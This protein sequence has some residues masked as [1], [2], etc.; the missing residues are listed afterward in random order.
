MPQPAIQHSSI[1]TPERPWHARPGRRAR[2]RP[3]IRTP[4]APAA[5]RSPYTEERQQPRESRLAGCTPDD[6]PP[7]RARPGERTP[8]RQED[9]APRRSPPHP[10]ADRAPGGYSEEYATAG[11]RN[12]A[13]T[14]TIRAQGY[15]G[16]TIDLALK[17]NGGLCCIQAV[18]PASTAAA[19]G[20]ARLSCRSG[21]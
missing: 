15:Y 1:C 10:A 19:F 9:H 14:S 6:P 20:S 21:R 13:M 17:C 16:P 18:E 11:M 12:A 2:H 7:A 5:P 3:S 8:A 4:I